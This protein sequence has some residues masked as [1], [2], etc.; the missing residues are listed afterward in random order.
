MLEPHKLHC[1]KAKV[2]PVCD[3]QG[4]VES[5]ERLDSGSGQPIAGHL[6]VSCWLPVYFSNSQ[7]P[8]RNIF[9]LVVLHATQLIVN[10]TLLGLHCAIK[11]R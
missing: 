11:R 10:P 3:V 8:L 6:V 2:A 5:A 9:Q 1:D 7:V 4:A